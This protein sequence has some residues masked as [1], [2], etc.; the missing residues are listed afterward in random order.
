MSE[1]RDRKPSSQ[2]PPEVRVARIT[3]QSAIIVALI[4]AVVSIAAIA[5]DFI[6]P[7]PTQRDVAKKIDE[8]FNQRVVKEDG[9]LVI[10]PLLP[11]GTIVASFLAPGQFSEAVGDPSVFDPA[12]SRWVQA[13]ARADISRSKYSKVT[14][15][16]RTPDLRGMFLRGANDGRTDDRKD[17][18]GDREP[19]QYQP[20]SVKRHSHDRPKDVFDSGGRDGTPVVGRD[21]GGLGFSWIAPFPKTGEYGEADETRPKNV[22]VFFYIRINV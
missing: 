7:P 5:K 3:S 16:S 19:G 22:A 8:T 15:R 9:K 11:V 13:D 21:G 4:S 14:G 12:K 18:D 17:P 6:N 10:S 1:V 2:E 20:D